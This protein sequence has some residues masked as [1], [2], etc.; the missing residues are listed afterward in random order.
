[1]VFNGYVMFFELGT[2]FVALA[3]LA[4]AKG[5]KCSSRT[6]KAGCMNESAFRCKTGLGAVIKPW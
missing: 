1:M 5:F 3:R 6:A 4:R 2:G